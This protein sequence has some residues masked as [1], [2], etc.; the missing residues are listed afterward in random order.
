MAH[1]A[2]IGIAMGIVLIRP[3]RPNIFRQA[4]VNDEDEYLSLRLKRHE[5]HQ[6]ALEYVRW[7]LQAHGVRMNYY[8][9][10]KRMKVFLHYIAKGSSYH[11]LGR[12]EGIVKSTCIAYLHDV[13]TFFHQTSATYV[14]AKRIILNSVNCNV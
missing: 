13:S 6:L 8:T 3:R 7:R 5:V 9:S 1:G 4:C 2:A 11:Q 10:V 14:W 12:V